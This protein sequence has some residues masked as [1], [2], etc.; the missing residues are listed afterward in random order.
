MLY[1]TISYKQM[2]PMEIS[3]EG[4]VVN[5]TTEQ[6]KIK[7]DRNNDLNIVHHSNEKY[8]FLS[9]PPE[10]DLVE[11]DTIH[12]L[13]VE[14]SNHCDD[15]MVDD[16]R[17]FMGYLIDGGQAFIYNQYT[18]WREFIL[19]AKYRSMEGQKVEIFSGSEKLAD[20]ILVDYELRDHQSFQIKSITLLT[21]FGERVFA[22]ELSI[23]ATGEFF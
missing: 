6:L 11:F 9:F 13:I 16:T 5:H 1:V 18:E 8:W 22:H 19:K 21:Q 17:A 14:L 20:G 3:F 4:S 2:N 10:L 12:R 15:A 7:L 23:A